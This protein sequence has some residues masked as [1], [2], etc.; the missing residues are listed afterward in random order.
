VPCPKHGHCPGL[1]VITTLNFYKELMK[2][3]IRVKQEAFG[4]LFV[5]DYM[6][7]KKRGNRISLTA[8]DVQRLGRYGLSPQNMTMAHV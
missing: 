7:Y 2:K 1:E 8:R 5:V 3:I 6:Y 4:E